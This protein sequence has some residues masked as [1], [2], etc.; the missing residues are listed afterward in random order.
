MISQQNAAVGE[1]A[2][3]SS[4]LQRLRGVLRPGGYDAGDCVQAQVK[5]AEDHEYATEFE[6]EGFCGGGFAGQVY[7]A[8]CV[9]TA[10]GPVAVG[11]I[12]ALKFFSPRSGMRRMF[13]DLLYRLCFLTPFP[14][15]FNEDSVR[16]GL[17]MTRL[18]QIAC[19][20]AMGSARPINEFYGTFWDAH[21]G[22]FAEV[23]EWVA[24]G[25]TDP[26]PDDQILLRRA[27]NRR[28]LRE[29]RRGAASEAD[30]LKPQDEMSQKRRFMAQLCS[31][32]AEMGL[33]DLLRQVYWWTGASQPN[34]LTRRDGTGPAGEPDFVWVDRRPGLPGLLLS[35][36]DFVLLARAFARG[37]IPPFDRINFRKLRAWPKAPDRREWEELVDR[38]EA[39][40]QGYRRTQVD[41]STHRFR[42]LGDRSLRRDIA[43]GVIDYWHR[44]GRVDTNTRD[45]LER[46]SARFTGHVLLSIIPFVGR[47]LQK[48]FGSE[49]YRQ[50]VS[51]FLREGAY[52]R[53]YFDRQRVGDV[54]V[55][56]LDERTTD[57]RAGKCLGCFPCYF[58]DRILC[59][60]MP[61]AWQRF[62][63]DWGYQLNCWCRL[64][65][66]P[67]RYVFVPAY[68]R[69]V[70]TLW[71]AN[72]TTED[73]RRGVIPQT[74][75]EEFVRIAG[76]KSIQQYVTGLIFVATV[77]SEWVYLLLGVLGV[78]LAKQYQMHASSISL[79]SKII[80]VAVAL[81]VSPG[82]IMR[83]FYCGVMGLFNRDVPYGTAMI[84]SPIRAV[85]DLAFPAQIGKTHP[86]FSA[87]L[88]TSTA[89]RLAEHV[90]VFG[91]RGGLLSLG[92]VTVVLSWPASMKAWWHA[93]RNA[94]P[95]S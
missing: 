73:L 25:V 51:R 50:H 94:T 35:F 40:D 76:H 8:H 37:S 58:A 78:H 65:T 91:E 62:F 13:R 1:E 18:L 64:F 19:G 3:R 81:L 72:R 55:W 85:G 12:V 83:F 67:F 54:K 29:I 87:Y 33:D 71:V 77:R 15:Q 24:G 11:Q 7:R 17:P 46:S 60:W 53:E 56:L 32:C 20:V 41:W 48:W 44:S 79:S 9:A 63:T 49:D 23:N 59:G 10:G 30:L 5:D 45:R 36:G 69:Q 31:L 2:P 84:M 43:A 38:L 89:C 16:A 82:G 52:R 27:H 95:S 26:L 75:A 4:L 47:R 21:V 34:V 90:P 42:I 28:K 66:S 74:D 14:Y 70:N 61:P 92:I 86:R 57:R 22:A 80:A 93:R 68:R 88:L 6:I 39:A